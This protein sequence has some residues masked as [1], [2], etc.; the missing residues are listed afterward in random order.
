MARARSKRPRK[1][2]VQ[3]VLFRWGGKRQGAGRKPKA[4]RAGAPHTRRPTLKERHPVHIVIRVVPAIGSLRKRFMY[5]A[6]REASITAAAREDFRIVHLSIQ[7][8]H[9]HLLVEARHKAALSRGMQG[10]Q[11]SAAKHLNTAVSTTW[12]ER[13]RGQVFADRYHA[14]I[15]ETPRQARHALN[16]VL[17]NW[18]KH[19]EDQAGFARAWKIDPFSS[20]IRFL[21]WKELAGREPWRKRDTYDPLVVCSPHTWLLREGWKLHG[22]L[23]VAEVPS[24]RR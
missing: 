5:K 2:H 19:R 15:I 4:G 17:N 22:L 7:R 12:S 18:R 8:T 24:R 16:Y 20:A 10:F 1:R 23:S 11:I 3:Q 9:V 6:L 14:E 21:D 13:R